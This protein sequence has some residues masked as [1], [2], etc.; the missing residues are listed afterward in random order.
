[1]LISSVIR[2]EASSI[3]L[4]ERDKKVWPFQVKYL[5]LVYKNIHCW[6]SCSC[7]FGLGAIFKSAKK[8]VYLCGGRYQK[9]LCRV[10]AWCY[11]ITKEEAR[12]GGRLSEKRRTEWAVTRGDVNLLSLQ[13]RPP[14][15]PRL[16]ARA[17]RKT[18]VCGGQI[19]WRGEWDS[20]APVGLVLGLHGGEMEGLIRRESPGVGGDGPQSLG[21]AQ[22]YSEVSE[23]ST[24]KN[25]N[26]TKTA[27][28]RQHLPFRARHNM[29]FL[30]RLLIFCLYI[31]STYKIHAICNILSLRAL[32]VDQLSA[33]KASHRVHN[34][35]Y[36]YRLHKGIS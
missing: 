33:F 18:G 26:T 29:L 11:G 25:W 7:T 31:C 12:R 27:P 19:L 10:V 34:K 3:Y 20:A 8:W 24:T 5:C 17:G 16:L 13:V 9:T 28:P 6:Q 32:I 4:C 30:Q 14:H 23:W 15:G 2:P 35:P 22:S 21:A 36:D 1:M